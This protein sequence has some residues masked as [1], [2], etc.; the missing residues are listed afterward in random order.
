MEQEEW[1]AIKDYIVFQV[2]PNG[3]DRATKKSFKKK[4]KRYK[5]DYE[6]DHSFHMSK[7]HVFNLIITGVPSIYSF[8]RVKRLGGELCWPLK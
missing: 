3:W 6:K 2:F 1:V 7:E 4:V 8:G 5:Y